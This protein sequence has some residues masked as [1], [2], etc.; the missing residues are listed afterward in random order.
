M[1]GH[2]IS[3][4]EAGKCIFPYDPIYLSEAEAFPGDSESGS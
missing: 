2:V 3:L 4:R 1:Q